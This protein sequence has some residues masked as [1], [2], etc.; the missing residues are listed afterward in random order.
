MDHA[1][2]ITKI[3]YASQVWLATSSAMV[4]YQHHEKFVPKSN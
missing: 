3:G 2:F 4:M 1:I